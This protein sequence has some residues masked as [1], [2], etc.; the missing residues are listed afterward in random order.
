MDQR[1]GNAAAGSRQGYHFDA[2]DSG[3]LKRLRDA[4]A[5]AY[6][7]RNKRLQNRWRKGTHQ[8]DEPEEAPSRSLADA[9]AS[10]D[11]AYKSKRKRLAEGWRQR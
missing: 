10:A 4:A 5:A 8:D 3:E 6:E 2:S 9:R 11:Q 7:E 1:S